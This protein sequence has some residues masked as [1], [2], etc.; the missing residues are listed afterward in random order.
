MANYKD[1]R[2]PRCHDDIKTVPEKN[3]NA[4]TPNDKIQMDTIQCRICGKECPI[5]A[6]WCPGCSSELV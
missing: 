5:N 4:E 3:E 1:K 2:D 6:E